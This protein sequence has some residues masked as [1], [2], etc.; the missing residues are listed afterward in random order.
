MSYDRAPSLFTMNEAKRYLDRGELPENL[1][2]RVAL[3]LEY[4][5]DNCGGR[6]CMDCIFRVYDHNCPKSA[7]DPGAC[8][9]CDETW[10][11]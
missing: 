9:A 4:G 6:R 5:C 11:A 2:D 3:A 8:P 10:A 1:R 7:G